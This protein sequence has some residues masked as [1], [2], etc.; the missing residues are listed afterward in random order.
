M[1]ITGHIPGQSGLHAV[2]VDDGRISAVT[3]IPD[4]TGREDQTW[5]TPGLFDIQ[6]NGIL[7]I[8]FTDP[9]TTVED[10]TRAD[11]AIRACGVS[12]YCPT[13]ITRD[14][15]TILALCGL[16]RGAW[17]QAAIPGAVGLHI[18]GPFI[19]SEDGYRGAHQRRFTRDPDYGELEQWQDASGGKVRIVTIAPERKGSEEFI[20]RATASGVRVALGHTNAD[21]DDV[22]RAA[23]AGAVL[24]THLFNGCAPMVNRHHNPIFAQLGEDRLSASFIADGHHIPLSALQT[25]LRAKGTQRSILVSDIVSLAGLEDGEY[26]ME[27]VTV[28]KADGGIW[29]SGEQILSGAA[30]TLDQDVEILARRPEPGISTVLAMA[31]L[32]PAALLGMEEDTRIGV[33][34][35][36]VL[37]SWRWDGQTLELDQ[38][39]GF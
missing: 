11:E 23:D 38:R 26:V 17:E 39:I 3:P 36:A 18:E 37:A 34:R 13:I 9:Q 19:S 1:R 12:R 27:E 28:I 16:F 20:R 35:P 6:I 5:I 21:E 25:A 30:R 10:L 2:E 32:H 15:Q 4:D 14:L 33:G 31:T 7:G 29:R 22:R 8:D 24:S